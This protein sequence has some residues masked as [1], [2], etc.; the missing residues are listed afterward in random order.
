MSVPKRFKTKR[1]ISG[2]NTTKIVLVKT[3]TIHKLDPNMLFIDHIKKKPSNKHLITF[4][5]KKA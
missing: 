4:F 5:Y 3:N 2:K 1:Q